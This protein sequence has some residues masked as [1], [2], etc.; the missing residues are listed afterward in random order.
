VIAGIWVAVSKSLTQA[1]RW[2][3]W[4]HSTE[5]HPDEITREDIQIALNRDFDPVRLNGREIQVL[6][7]AWLSSAISQETVL[8]QMERGGLLPP[9]R[10][11]EE[12]MALIKANPPPPARGVSLGSSGGGK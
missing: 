1:L 12:E 9:G 5:D 11:A 10:S 7:V 2:V 8:H 6:V 4:W 3:Y